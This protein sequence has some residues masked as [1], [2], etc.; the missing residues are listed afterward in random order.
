MIVEPTEISNLIFDI[1]KKSH[2]IIG[3]PKS[4][5]LKHIPHLHTT[6]T[7][8]WNTIQRDKVNRQQL[9]PTPII[10]NR[11]NTKKH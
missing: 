8:A 4:D 3:I 1:G 2:I 11:V 9:I 7:K 10:R 5:F 6:A